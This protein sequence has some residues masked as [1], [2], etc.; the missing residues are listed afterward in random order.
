MS[1][2]WTPTVCPVP[3]ACRSM[4]PT[5]VVQSPSRLHGFCH[6]YT[7]YV[8]TDCLASRCTHPNCL[9]LRV[10]V[11]TRPIPSALLTPSSL[12]AS[13]CQTSR[14]SSSRA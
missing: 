3:P 5:D 4:F 12:C 2:R 11:T 8:V 13:T 6:R 9:T 10:Y 1:T 7:A 14:L